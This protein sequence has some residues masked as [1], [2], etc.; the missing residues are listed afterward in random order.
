MIGHFFFTHINTEIGHRLASICKKNNSLTFVTCVDGSGIC[1]D[2]A[3]DVWTVGP[4]AVRD[5]DRERPRFVFGE[6][7]EHESSVQL[8][9][10]FDGDLVA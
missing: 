6:H 7:T 9:E 1:R 2:R 3:F 10:L 8:T 5:V 4:C